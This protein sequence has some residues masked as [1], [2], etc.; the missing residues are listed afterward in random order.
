MIKDRVILPLVS[1]DLVLAYRKNVTGRPLQ[2]LLQSSDCRARAE[3]ETGTEPGGPAAGLCR[4]AGT[5]SDARSIED[6]DAVV[7]GGGLSGLYAART[8][9][10]A[11]LRVVVLEARDRVGGLTYSPRSEV[12]GSRL[13]LGGQWVAPQH[14]RMSALI[15]EYDVPFVK[16]YMT[17]PAGV[18]ARREGIPGSG[19]H[20]PRPDGSG[21]GR[22][23][24]GDQAAL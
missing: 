12:L 23:R 11:G 7:I 21:R 5:T 19:R 13:D 9:Q 2:R 10:R 14:A 15:R 18:P 20:H 3:V 6:A 1:P 16:Q 22:I 4:Q 8:L 24:R 17:G